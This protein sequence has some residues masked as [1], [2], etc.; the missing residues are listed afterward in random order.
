MQLKGMTIKRGIEKRQEQE[1]A[2]GIIFLSCR[3]QMPH[4]NLESHE[5]VLKK[6]ENNDKSMYENCYP[7]LS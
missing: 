3:Q 4:C 7:Y 1:P 6:E 5:C 2:G